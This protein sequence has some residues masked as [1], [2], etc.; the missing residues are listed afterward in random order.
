MESMP[1]DEMSQTTSARWL[2]TAAHAAFVPIGIVTVL[3]GPLL[4]TLS[5]RWSLN[6]L[7]AGSLFT[8]QFLGSTLGVVVSGVLV[9]RWGFRF[10]INAGLLVMAV[11]V[12]TLPFSS[13]VLGLIC[14]SCYGLGLGLAIPAIN[15]FVADVNPKRRSAALSLL[16][17]SWSVGAVACPFVVA[18]AVRLDHIQLFLLMLAGFLLLVFLGIL[19]V[20]FIFVAP[21]TAPKQERPDSSLFRWNR[22]SLFVLAALFFLYVGTENGFGGWIASYAKSLGSSSPT[23]PVMTPSF[24]YAA[25]M[26]GRW[27]APFVLRKTGEIRAAQS[28]LSIACLGMVGL[29]LSRT[30]P[31]VVTSVSVAGL[32]LAAVYPITISRL[33]QEFGPAATRAGSVMFTMANLG[34]ACLPWVVGYSSQR[35]NDLRAGLAVPL[36]ATLVMYALYRGNPGSAGVQVQVG[37]LPEPLK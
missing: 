23:L 8:A 37:R 33:S 19:A 7:Q 9:S 22:R 3:L 6:Y 14:I 26:L 32:G 5:A 15:L 34:G 1:P 31:L 36:A 12:G 10:A 17:F 20:P 11:G 29:V 28:G 25:L 4:P 13:R 16:N 21:A 27:L 30:M 35:L 18:A 24:F 2:N